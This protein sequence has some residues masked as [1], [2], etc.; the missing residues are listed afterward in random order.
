M[1]PA[2]VNGLVFGKIHNW[3]GPE[4]GAGQRGIRKP[5]ARLW[6]T[7]TVLANGDVALCCLDYDGQHLLGHIDAGTSLRNVWQGA[8]YQAI[9]QRHKD[10]RQCEIA[11]CKDCSKSFCGPRSGKPAFPPAAAV[12]YNTGMKHVH[13]AKPARRV[14]GQKVFLAAVVL[15]CVVVI[16]GML[17]S[18]VRWQRNPIDG[19]RAYDYLKR[20]CDFGPR[21]SG[22]PAMIA[23]RQFLVNY[24]KDLG[25]Q[26]ELQDFTA[27]HPLD[28]SKVP[29]ANIIV[30]WNPQ[31]KERILLCGHYDTLPFPMHDPD[32]PQGRFVGANDNASGIALLMELAHHMKG[33]HLPYGVDFVLFDAEEFIFRGR[34]RQPLFPG[35]GTLRPRVCRRPA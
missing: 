30:H 25:G 1:L 8:A 6:R 7:L 24:F 15:L 12:A 18:Q 3:A 17:L 35:L 21:R 9:R 16:G 4:A 2:A 20:L 27:K 23:Q 22:S 31:Y 32:D 10:A 33:L 19:Q 29:M 34:P 5:C 26:V 13:K 14:S 28:G 11:L